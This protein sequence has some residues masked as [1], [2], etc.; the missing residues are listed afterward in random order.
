METNPSTNTLIDPL[1]S[2]PINPLPEARHQPFPLTDMQL[3]YWVGRNGAFDLGQVSTHCYMEIESN[4]VDIGRLEHA[5]QQMIQRHAM[6]HTIVLPDGQQRVLDQVP[7]YEI[8]VLDLRTKAACEVETKLEEIRTRMSHQVLPSDQWPLFEIKATHLADNR[9]RFHFSMDMLILDGRSQALLFYEWHQLYRDPGSSLPA[10]EVSFRDY[11]MA[12][13]ALKQTDR[14]RHDLDY[15]LERAASLPLAPDL[16]LAANPPSSIPPRFNNHLDRLDALAWTRLK[17]KATREGLSPLAVLLA[18]YVEVLRIW[19]KNPQFSINITR[20]NR[21]ADDWRLKNVI[22]NYTSSLIL[23]VGKPDAVSFSVHAQH[24]EQ[25]LRTDLDHSSVSG[26]EVVRELN[27]QNSDEGQVIMPVV[28]TSLVGT[29]SP[30]DE[31]KPTAWLGESDWLGKN[32]YT[33][34]QASQVWID[35]QTHE[36]A[37]ELLFNWN[38]LDALFPGNLISDM[39]A[40]FSRLLHQLSRDDGF[41]QT[42]WTEAAELLIPS[43]QRNQRDAINNTTGPVSKALLHTLFTDQ[44]SLQPDQPALLSTKR[45]LTYRQLH[46]HSSRVAHWLR[47]ENARPGTLVAVVMEKGWEQVVGVIGTLMSGAAYLPI[48]AD[49]P[50]DRIRYL[51]EHGQVALALT[52]SWHNDRIDWPPHIK[53]LCIDT[54]GDIPLPGDPI[55]TVQA[56]EDLAYVIYT[57]GSTGTPKGVMID[58]RGAVNTILDVN[59][60]FQVISSDRVLAL[61]ALNFDL[62]VYDIFGMLAAGGAV[63]IPDVCTERDPLHWFKMICTYQVTIWETVPAL[64]QML[65]EYLACRC[66]KLPETLRLVMMSGDWIPVD[67]PERIRDLTHNAKIVSLGGATEAS[68]WSILHPIERVDASLP[69]IPYGKPMRNQTFH[70]FDHMLIP[71][72]VWVPGQLYIGGIGLAKGYWRDAE[73]TTASFVWH[74]KRA[75]RLYRTGDMGRYLPD[76]NIEF[77]GREDFQVKIRGHRIE[78][79]EIENVLLQHPQIQAAVVSAEGKARGSERLVAYLV[80]TDQPPCLSEEACMT[81]VQPAAEICS[82]P[83]LADMLRCFLEGKLP[84]YMIPTAFVK[85]SHLPLTPNGKIDRK[86]L[87][88]PD[89]AQY[90]DENGYMPCRDSLDV[91]IASIWQHVLRIDIM[92]IREN[93]FELGGHSLQAI[94][95]LS[96]IKKRIGKDIAVANFFKAPTVEGLADIIH[97]EGWTSPFTHLF[98]VSTDGSKPVFFSVFIPA[99]DAKKLIRPG[100]PFFGGAPHGFDGTPIPPTIEELAAEFVSE[101]KLI[102]PEGPYFIGGYSFGGLLA[103]EIASQLKNEGKKIGGLILMDPMLPGEKARALNPGEICAVTNMANPKPNNVSTQLAIRWQRFWHLP[104]REKIV[105]LINYTYWRLVKRTGAEARIKQL[106]CKGLMMA[107]CP[108]PLKLK[109]FSYHQKYSRMSRGYCPTPYNGEVF[110]L[111]TTE[112]AIHPEIFWQDYIS[113]PL[114]IHEVP[115]GHLQ[116]FHEPN[117]QFVAEKF[118]LCLEKAQS[119][120]QAK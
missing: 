68:I 65:V 49:L 57:S 82:D 25:R 2:P 31:T 77:L 90:A 8:G 26:I 93:F 95:V 33:I 80:H 76:G 44:V 113:E 73:K 111:K 41:W 5:W 37:G 75:E 108:V 59:Q 20:S 58:H 67:L 29:P 15:W 101:I 71:R 87:P 27:R 114:E 18:A 3:A 47:L 14:Y 61:S 38:A 100:Q 54:A 79:G 107:G 91:Q 62:S 50:G 28:F 19:S 117:V 103:F 43:A 21:L 84:D 63:V 94:Q 16:P 74:P 4:H 6:L 42:D 116:F 13:M 11:V 102:Q 32:I 96:Q 110:F 7:A 45:T 104:P 64:M 55:Q 88:M 120:K 70:V 36:Q 51:L 81:H 92:G 98:P 17:R 1:F 118:N 48:N 78:L 52:Q 30:T 119:G 109:Q 56:P 86:S 69:S 72:P 40:A 39:F 97:S 89:Q 24:I 105:K 53:R 22:G 46:D 10:C 66:E 115:G 23:D 34:S 9:Y 99:T 85:L 106:A 83:F 60:R 12:E 35:C 112:E